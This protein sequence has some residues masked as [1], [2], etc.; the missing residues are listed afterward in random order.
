MAVEEVHVPNAITKID[1]T[2]TPEKKDDNVVYWEGQVKQARAKREFLQEQKLAK[3][4]QDPEL[5]PEPPFKVT[6]GINLGNIDIQEQQRAAREEALKAQAEAQ[7]RVDEAIKERDTVREALANAQMRHLQETLGNQIAQLQNAIQGGKRPDIVS[8]LEAVEAIA[9]RLGLSRISG[10]GGSDT[11]VMLQVKKLEAD[12]KREERRFQLDMKKDERMWQ[13]ELKKLEHQERESAARVEAERNKYNMI[14][15]LPEQF[16][17]VVAKGLLAHGQGVEFSQAE[18]ITQ[19]PSVPP[20]SQQGGG[21]QIRTIQA[22]VGE[23]GEIP[24]P[25]CGTPVGVAPSTQSTQC[26]HCHQPFV[27]QRIEPVAEG[28]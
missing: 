6:G 22:P 17:T 16:G 11:N 28:A 26:A 5:P 25:T 24:C 1:P 9:G 7:K 19:R 12:L 8:E 18:P 27:I 3:E 2:R 20:P 15:A 13:L 23:G 21:M 4:I 14:A 10:G